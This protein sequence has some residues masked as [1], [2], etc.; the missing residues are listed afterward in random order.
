VTHEEIELLKEIVEAAIEE[1]N[2]AC[3][4]PECPLCGTHH[5]QLAK[6]QRA[7]EILESLE[8]AF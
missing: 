2:W 7:K 1:M 8:N 3:G 5:T 6:Y 4:D